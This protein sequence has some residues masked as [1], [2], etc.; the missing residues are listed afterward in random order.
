[1]FQMVVVLFRKDDEIIFEQY[2]QVKKTKNAV[3]IVL[4]KE[5]MIH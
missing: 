3:A 2:K 5:S 1:M 4:Y